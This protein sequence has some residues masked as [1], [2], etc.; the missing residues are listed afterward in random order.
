MLV[1]V[2]CQKEDVDGIPAYIEINSIS[3][4]GASTDPNITDAWVYVNDQLQGIYELPA[5]FPVLE[6]GIQILKVR[7]GIKA[8]GIASNRMYYPFYT[9]DTSSVEFVE[10][11]NMI[12]TPTVSY[13]NNI[14]ILTEDYGQGTGLDFSK[15]QNS[16]TTII[17]NTELGFG[18]GILD[19]SLVTFEIATNEL[20]NLPQAG[21]PVFFELDYKSNTQFLIGVLIKFPHSEMPLPKDLLWVNPKEDWNKIYV[22]LTSTISEGINATYFK[23]F[24]GMKRDTELDVNELCFDNLKVVY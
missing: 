18:S 11:E 21:S 9:S 15:T 4:T 22:N 5:K 1:I 16:D 12:L 13:L 24:I 20:K 23:V 14:N 2:S 17:I 6:K 3:L 19:S 7:A 8:N 10:N